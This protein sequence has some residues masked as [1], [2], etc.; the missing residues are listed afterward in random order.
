MLQVCKHGSARRG[1]REEDGKEEPQTAVQL[2][3]RLNLADGES[4]SQSHLLE[5]FYVSLQWA[6]FSIL[7]ILSHWLG[8]VGG[9]GDLSVNMVMDPDAVSPL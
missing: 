2:L 8:A 5:E 1:Q 9:K 3:E 6:C 7:A 4:L